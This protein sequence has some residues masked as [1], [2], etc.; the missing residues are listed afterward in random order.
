M[1]IVIISLLILV[2]LPVS[3]AWIAGYYRQKQF[4]SVDNKEPR[5]QSQ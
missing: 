1:N 5:V 2:I 4:G 3:C